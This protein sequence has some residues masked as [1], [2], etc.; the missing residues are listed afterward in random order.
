MLECIWQE[1]QARALL[2]AA[3]SVG[4]SHAERVIYLFSQFL[5]YL[6]VLLQI[7][8]RNLLL[9]LHPPKRG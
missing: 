2:L 9:P 7:P 5:A 1:T 6:P 3:A 4:R 8:I